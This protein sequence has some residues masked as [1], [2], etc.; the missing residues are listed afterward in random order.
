L[1]NFN[2]FFQLKKAHIRSFLIKNLFRGYVIILV[3]GQKSLI[4]EPKE[5]EI[6]PSPK[7]DQSSAETT[8]EPEREKEKVKAVPQDSKEVAEQKPKKE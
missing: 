5:P 6:M 3:P 7:V 4:E 1:S 8:T 2:H